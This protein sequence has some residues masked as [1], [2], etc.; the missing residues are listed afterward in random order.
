MNNERKL[1]LHDDIQSLDYLFQNNNIQN[2]NQIFELLSKSIPD[3]TAISDRRLKSNNTSY[4][5]K[6]LKEKIDLYTMKL[7][8]IW[9]KKWEKIWLISEN[10]PESIFLNLAAQSI[11]VIIVPWTEETMSYWINQSEAMYIAWVNYIFIASNIKTDPKSFIGL[12]KKQIDEWLDNNDDENL[13]FIETLLKQEKIFLMDHNSDNKIEDLWIK[14]KVKWDF[15]KFNSRSYLWE[16]DILNEA[17]KWVWLDTP[18]VI[19]YCSWTWDWWVPKSVE[20]THW[21]ILHQIK[22]CPPVIW[23]EIWDKYLEVLPQHHIF[24]YIARYVIFAAGWELDLATVNDLI[25]SKLSIL[26]DSNPNFMIAVTRIWA[27]LKQK[28]EKNIRDELKTANGIKRYILEWVEEAI[29]IDMCK[30]KDND[31]KQTKQ[32]LPEYTEKAEKYWESLNSLEKECKNR[33]FSLKQ[34]LWRLIWY[35]SMIKKLWLEDIKIVINWWW[36]LPAPERAFFE[37]LWITIKPWYWLTE[38]S[39]VAALPSLNNSWSPAFVSWEILE[40]TQ[41]YTKLLEKEW[42]EWYYE[43]F[44]KGPHIWKYTDEKLNE[45]LIPNWELDTWDLWWVLEYNGKKY[46]YI[47][48]RSKNI[49]KNAWW[50]TIM[51]ELYEDAIRNSPYID[52]C[53]IVWSEQY[54]TLW[55][56]IAYNSELCKWLKK[57]DL[58]KLIKEEI[59][60]TTA[61]IW[62]KVKVNNFMLLENWFTNDMFSRSHKLIKPK[63][64]KK[65]SEEINNM[66]SE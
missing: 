4:S 19:M 31:I 59:V 49:I 65:Y 53:M 7:L 66:M 2:L 60:K 12:N 35:K 23:W 51:P 34:A 13:L 41:I 5:Y 55:V 48:W 46:V 47:E 64:M 63:V 56:I 43:I 38:N 3:N 17:R 16:S 62:Q 39:A 37:A 44:I 45:K 52:E 54:K 28:I 25:L 57:E 40:W 22:N 42:Y 21:N 10:S 30:V 27:N 1:K 29:K 58:E 24:Q 32:N 50:E 11:W 9:V 8:S 15:L 6:E 20:I 26:K 33:I 14:E 36:G 18:A 61:D